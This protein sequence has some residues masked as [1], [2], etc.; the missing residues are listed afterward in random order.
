MRRLWFTGNCLFTL[1]PKR[2]I[3][4][5]SL[6]GE[7]WLR[8]GEDSAVVDLKKAMTWIIGLLGLLIVVT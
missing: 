4:F 5:G 3:R 1:L 7:G 2:P 6:G 8:R